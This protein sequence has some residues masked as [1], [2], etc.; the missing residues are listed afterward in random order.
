MTKLVAIIAGDP[1]SIST[2]LI[3]KAWKKRELYK[4]IKVF[5]IGNYK[6]IA[7]QL[8]LLKIKIN[9]KK[10]SDLKE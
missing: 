4:N 9:I 10:I 8:T 7:K 6:L 3:A 5:V 2:E 1:E